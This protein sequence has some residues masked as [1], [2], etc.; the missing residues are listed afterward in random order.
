MGKKKW[1]LMKHTPNNQVPSENTSH[2]SSKRIVEHS[3]GL[4]Q[5]APK[6]RRIL[7]LERSESITTQ[8]NDLIQFNASNIEAE[9]EALLAGLRLAKTMKVIRMQAYTNSLLITKQVSREYEA[10]GDLMIAYMDQL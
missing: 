9:Y 1:S 5:Y 4:K 6:K 3:L 10:K 8:V 2:P 7:S